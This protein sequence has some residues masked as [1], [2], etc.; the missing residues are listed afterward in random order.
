MIS[1]GFPF[2]HHQNGSK[3]W[4]NLF[5]SLLA[6]KVVCSLPSQLEDSFVPEKGLE[7]LSL[8]ACD[9]ESHVYAIPPLRRTDKSTPL[10]VFAQ[11][12]LFVNTPIVC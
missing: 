5:K 6:N 10:S 3:I 12:V 11:Q 2:S 1:T 9:F 7:P 8:A 4:E